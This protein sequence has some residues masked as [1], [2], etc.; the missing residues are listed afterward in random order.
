VEWEGAAERVAWHPPYTLPF[1]SRFIE[2]RHV[3]TGRLVQIVSG[4]DMRWI[5][6]GWG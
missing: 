3:E 4:N 6:D 2:I 5:W 1:D